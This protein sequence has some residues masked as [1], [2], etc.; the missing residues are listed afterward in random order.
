MKIRKVNHFLF[1]LSAGEK[2]PLVTKEKAIWCSKGYGPS[3]S[4][5]DLEIADKTFYNT[6]SCANFPN[7]LTIETFKLIQVVFRHSVAPKVQVMVS[8]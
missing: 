5:P 3:F 8:L 6:N 7:C 1:N 2:Y 4:H